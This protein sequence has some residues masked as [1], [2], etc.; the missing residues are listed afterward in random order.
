MDQ[1]AQDIYELWSE[2]EPALAFQ[3]GNDRSVGKFFNPTEDNVQDIFRRIDVLRMDTIDSTNHAILN[4]LE[5][6]IKI[7]EP[8]RVLWDAIWGYF[9]YLTKEGINEQHMKELTNNIIGSLQTIHTNLNNKSWS[10]EIKIITVNN[11]NGLIGIIDS[12]EKNA[13]N[14][15]PEFD[16][17]RNELKKY[18]KRYQVPE[19]KVG[20]FSEV[21]PL[22]EKKGGNIGRKLIYPDILRN[23]WGYLESAEEIESLALTWLNTERP[24]LMEITEKLALKLNV[25]ADVEK[26]NDAL[27]KK[28]GIKQKMALEFIKDLRIPLRKIVEKNVVEITPKYK[29]D[30][31]ETPGYLLNFISTAA[32]TP[33]DIHTENP[34]NVFFVTTDAKRSPPTGISDL[35]Q[36]IIHEEYGHCVHFSN[37]ATKF[38]ATPSDVDMIY[39]PMAIPISDGISF[40]REY[41]S[42]KLLR[43]IF[44]KREHE[45]DNDEKTLLNLI[46]SKIA[47]DVFLLEFEFT[48]MRWRIIRFLRAIGD[49]RINMHKQSLTEFITWAS[50]YSGLSKKFIFDQIFLFQ[51]RPGYA[52]CYSIVGN[53]IQE[54]QQ[55]AKARGRSEIDFNSFASS[56]GFP[57][58]NVFEQRLNDF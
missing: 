28:Y 25:E 47:L 14:L 34:F 3:C 53:R 35:F 37:S 36:L 11:Y 2:L 55:K 58:R 7:Q 49:V 51:V 52:P 12:I 18:M 30:V 23:I 6:K 10:T 39:T 21:F 43:S 42:L 17:L 22:L 48:I 27:V 31:I 41:E 44:A 24:K 29:T 32:M 38:R 13:K 9:G 54:Y 26:V 20:D 46:N 15:K 8:Y 33:F 1:V 5:T 40:F 50:E 45:M 57:P 4:C 16:K 56:L 19:I